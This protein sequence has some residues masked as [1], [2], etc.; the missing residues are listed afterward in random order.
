MMAGCRVDGAFQSLL[1]NYVAKFRG[2]LAGLFIVKELGFSCVGSNAILQWLF[3]HFRIIGFLSSSS[4]I[5]EVSRLIHLLFLGRSLVLFESLRIAS[6]DN[7]CG[8]AVLL[9]M[10]LPKVGAAAPSVSSFFLSLV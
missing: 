1:A 8:A 2:V 5:G 9:L 4:R 10:A 6:L 7:A 3:W